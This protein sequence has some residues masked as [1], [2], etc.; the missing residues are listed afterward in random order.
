ME[1]A[2][3]YPLDAV[4]DNPNDVPEDVQIS[5]LFLK[6]VTYQSDYILDDVFV[7]LFSAD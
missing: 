1:I 6:C 2:K 5:C 3:I 7:V 4:F